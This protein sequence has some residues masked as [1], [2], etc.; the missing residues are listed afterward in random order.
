M[1]VR[2]NLPLSLVCCGLLMPLS[3][4]AGM[5]PDDLSQLTPGRT[6]AENAL[7]IENAL[8]A[9][10]NS[11]KQVTVADLKGPAVITMIHFAMPQTLKLNRDVLLRIFWDGE[12][13]PS[14]EVPLVD[15]FCDPAGLREEVNTALVN[16]RRGFNAYSRWLF[17][18][19]REW[20]WSMTVRSPRATS[21][22]RSC[23]A[24]AM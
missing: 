10:F 19:A 11:S 21:C 5:W 8:S 15:F 22:G 4:V 9:R 3:L 2:M 20:N 7:W 1:N 12:A 13:S 14:V 18:S 16:K 23:L 24:T 17:A 6:R